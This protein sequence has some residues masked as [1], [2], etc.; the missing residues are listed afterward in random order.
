MDH[1]V[2]GKA[3]VGIPAGEE[4]GKAEVLGTSPAEPAGPAGPPEP[5]DAHPVAKREASY[6]RSDLVDGAH[7]L[8][9][10]HHLRSV[11]RKVTLG[12]M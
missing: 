9:T 2:L 6:P 4:R 10:G 11:N 7:D 1:R 12:Q 8:V 5:G 3:A